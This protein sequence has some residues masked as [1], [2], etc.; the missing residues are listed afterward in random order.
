MPIIG[1]I[2]SSISSGLADT[3]AMV[4]LQVVTVS[5]SGASSVSFSNIPQDYAHLQIRAMAQPYYGSTPGGGQVSM[6]F[7]GDTN[8][9]YTRHGLFGDGNSVSAIGYSTGTYNY[10]AIERFYWVNSS[11]VFGV[12]VATVLDYANS[13]KTKTVLSSGGWDA[14]GSGE[15]VLASGLWTGTAAITS[16]SIN[17]PG[18]TLNQYSQ[19]ALYGIKAAS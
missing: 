14:N 6:R 11:S 18:S 7:N 19:F 16:I 4:P 5:G 9:N 17:P 3:G 2:A 8:Q 1:I 13:N 10:I 15:V 12:S